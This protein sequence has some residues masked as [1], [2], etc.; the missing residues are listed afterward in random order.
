ME[1]IDTTKRRT[2]LILLSSC[3]RRGRVRNAR[4]QLQVR[5]QKPDRFFCVHLSR[6]IRSDRQRR[7]QGHQRVR[8]KSEYMPKRILR[9]LVR[10][11]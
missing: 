6:R 2:S 3:C 5:V 4:Q 9:Q 1:T 11:V 7:V 8:G 10:H